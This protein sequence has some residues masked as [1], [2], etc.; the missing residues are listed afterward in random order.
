MYVGSKTLGVLG[1][2]ILPFVVILIKV[3][4]DAGLIHVFRDVHEGEDA[5]VQKGGESPAE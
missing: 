1:F 3:Y 5:E 4:N 2:F